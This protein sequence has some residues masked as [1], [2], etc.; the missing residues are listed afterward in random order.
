MGVRTAVGRPVGDGQSGPGWDVALLLQEFGDSATFQHG[1][2]GA[3]AFHVQIA[4]RHDGDAERAGDGK[5]RIP[6]GRDDGVIDLEQAAVAPDAVDLHAVLIGQSPAE[7]DDEEHL[8]S[9]VDGDIDERYLREHGGIAND[10]PHRAVL[11]GVGAGDL[12]EDG[13]VFAVREQGRSVGTD[14]VAAARECRD[15]GD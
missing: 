8:L 14:L 3:E 4:T 1:D 15:E 5:R 12:V 6:I 11:A 7:G 13:K 10:E 2:R 9:E